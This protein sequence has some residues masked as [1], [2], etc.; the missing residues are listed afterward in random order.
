MRPRTLALWLLCV[1]STGIAA[2]ET[3][4]RADSLTTADA[5]LDS[6][7]RT[8]PEVMITGERPVV[9]TE[10]GKLVYDLPRLIRE[11]PVN[12]VYEAV[13]ELPGITES[14]G[15]LQLAGQ[16][17]S[18]ILD[19]KVTTLSQPQ[20][21]ALLQSIPASRIERA[22][23]MYNAPARYQVRGA[24]I[25]ITLR[26]AAGEKSALQGEL[27]GQYRQRHNASFTER[28]S[29]LYARKRW[30]FDLLYSHDHGRGYSTTDKEALHTLADGSTHPIANHEFNLGRSHTHHFRAGADYRIAKDH[31]LSFVYTGNHSVSHSLRRTLGTE[32][33]ATRS[34]SN[35]RLHNGRL[36]YQTPFGLQA[37]AELTYYRSPSDQLLHSRMQEAALDFY[38]ED[39][40]R[41]NRWKFFLGQEH[42]L[43]EGGSLNYGAVYTTSID[44]SH[45]YYY[46]EEGATRQTSL[47]AD[48]TSRRREET[49]NLYA[50][51]GKR[52]GK[53][54]SLEVSLAA[55]R[56][57]TPVWDQW[58]WYPTLNL[59]YMPADGHILQ[60]GLSSDKDYPDYWAVQEATSYMGSY[61]EIRGN[62]LLRPSQEYKL[63]LT[64]IL[65]NKYVFSTW[66]THEKD[67]GV[68]TLYQSPDRLTEIYKYLNFDYRQQAGIQASIPFGIG[69]WLS[70]RLT[71]IG[72]W[73]HEKDRDFW[74]LPFDRRIC[75]GIAVMNHTLRLATRPDLKLTLSGMVHSKAIQ[76]IYDLPAAGY[77]NLNLRYAFAGQRAVVN[78]YCNDLF[79]T[80]QISPRIRFGTQQVTNRYS[81]FRETGISL[82]WKF[83]GYKEKKREEV[84]TSRFK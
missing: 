2:Q 43:K 62:P 20:L 67:Y 80:S 35:D 54:L 24:L 7:F 63:Q 66:F 11:L 3:T 53:R 78:L 28:A 4:L 69:K 81:C 19:G 49:L 75:Y 51:F 6:L 21:T 25:N 9:K 45:Q 38:T 60:L 52:F 26:R 76:G 14:N 56:Y 65:K 46:P 40:Q 34:N 59:H 79:E 77:A 44:H 33:A 70:S 50:G 17:V 55:E 42:E 27:F 1:A 13:K 30:S 12:N 37:G 22:E 23:V 72:T 31:Q 58:D 82:T 71:L 8:L 61:S 10:P 57:K 73:L 41:I 29:L 5:R 32:Q 48:M 39:C 83:G 36:D 64:Y 74:D 18:V 16:A 68:Q 84:D 15:R 47:P